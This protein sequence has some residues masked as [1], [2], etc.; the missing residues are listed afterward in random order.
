MLELELPPHDSHVKVVTC[1]VYMLQDNLE[2]VV[3]ATNAV[4]SKYYAVCDLQC[5]DL[6]DIQVCVGGE[7]IGD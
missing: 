6:C 7:G 2:I 5:N 4:M 3:M 1:V